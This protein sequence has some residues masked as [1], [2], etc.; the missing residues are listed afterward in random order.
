MTCIKKILPCLFFLFSGA[1]TSIYK[2]DCRICSSKGCPIFFNKNLFIIFSALFIPPFYETFPK[3]LSYLISSYSSPQQLPRPQVNCPDS[4]RKP[5]DLPMARSLDV[6]ATPA[7]INVDEADAAT[8]DS[9]TAEDILRDSPASK[10]ASCLL[11][12]MSLNNPWINLDLDSSLL[13]SSSFL[14]SPQRDS[15]KI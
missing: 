3:S 14:S 11:K 4:P 15:R 5:G 8:L 13:L 9:V 2:K 10:K 12:K 1:S 7:A 6:A